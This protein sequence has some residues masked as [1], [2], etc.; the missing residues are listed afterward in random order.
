MFPA[1]TP[2]ILHGVLEVGCRFTLASQITLK[3][4]MGKH[5]EPHF[6]HVDDIE[7]VN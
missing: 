3:I 6:M 5:W 4:V 7:Q 2:F 1:N